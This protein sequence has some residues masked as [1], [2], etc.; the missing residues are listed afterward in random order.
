MVSPQRSVPAV[1]LAP[2]QPRAARSLAARPVVEEPQTGAGRG[3]QSSAPAA[4][5]DAVRRG[6]RLARRDGLTGVRPVRGGGCASEVAP[7]KASPAPLRLTR[8][9]RRVVAGLSMAI[10][11][12]IAAVT[13]AV[14]VA[15][16]GGLQLAGSSTVVVQPGDTLWSLAERLAPQ[17]DPRAVIDA[18]VDLNGL[19]GTELLPGQVLDLP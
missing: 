18:I 9:G 13:V 15:S 12:G 7:R 8:R 14:E 1:C 10:G 3:P 17:E 6:A 19:A 11:L 5:R 4:R 2:V 16:G